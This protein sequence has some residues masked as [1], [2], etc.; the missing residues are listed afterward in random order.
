MEPRAWTKGNAVQNGTLR[1]QSREGA[2]H[3]LD[4]IRQIAKGN[5][6]EKFTALLHHVTVEALE[7]A[8]R[9]PRKDAAPGVDGVTWE[10]FEKDLGPKLEDLHSRIHRGA[11]RAQ[12]SLR[13]LIPKPDG[14]MR[15]LAIAALEDKIVQRALAT[16]LNAIYE[17]DFLDFSYGFRPGRG[18]MT[19]WA[20]PSIARRWTS[21]WTP[22]SRSSSIR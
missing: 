15:P 1:T 21:Y 19:R 12:L 2:S 10:D 6:K 7:E 18:R 20:T 3:G 9:E 16:V 13:V 11:Y 17:E 8:F 14:R 5:G 22:A 4:R